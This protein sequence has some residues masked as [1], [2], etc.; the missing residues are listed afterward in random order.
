MG[1]AHAHSIR[2]RCCTSSH[3]PH[4]PDTWPS[5][6]HVTPRHTAPPPPAGA[7]HGSDALLQSAPGEAWH[8]GEASASSQLVH[9]SG[10]VSSAA[11]AGGWHRRWGCT[12]VRRRACKGVQ[13]AAGEAVRDRGGS[14]SGAAHSGAPARRPRGL[15][16]VQHPWRQQG[17]PAAPA[18]ACKQARQPSALRSPSSAGSRAAAVS[19]STA[20]TAR[21]RAAAQARGGAA[22]ARPP[23]GEDLGGLSLRPRASWECLCWPAQCPGRG[24][25]PWHQTEHAARLEGHLTSPSDL[26]RRDLSCPPSCCPPLHEDFRDLQLQ[27]S[28]HAV[29]NGPCQ[30]GARRSPPPP[31]GHAIARRARGRRRRG[32]CAA[33]R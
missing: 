4:I 3:R 11:A 2:P 19:A 16:P 33:L 6:S 9:S 8:A 31:R 12:C 15:E 18:S 24:C 25:M 21:A 17:R 23:A 22:I 1:P 13:A 32:G 14:W 28:S 27:P 26:G 5:A 20:R 29:C 7:P 30:E 10:R